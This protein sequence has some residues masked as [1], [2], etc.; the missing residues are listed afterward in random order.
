MQQ[1]KTNPIE[2]PG[3]PGFRKHLRFTNAGTKNAKQ[4]Q[5]DERQ[6]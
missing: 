6:I 2:D 5:F 1:R 3:A 4:T